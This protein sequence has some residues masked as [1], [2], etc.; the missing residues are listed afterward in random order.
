MM[1]SAVAALVT[2]VAVCAAGQ[3]PRSKPIVVLVH[4]RACRHS[5]LLLIV[6]LNW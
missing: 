6:S 5:S 3:K 1:K 2:S 4:E